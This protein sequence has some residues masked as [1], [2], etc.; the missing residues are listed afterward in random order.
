MLTRKPVVRVARADAQ[1][2]LQA[3]FTIMSR[4]AVAAIGG[5]EGL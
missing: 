3:R 1:V 4:F 5:H 2:L